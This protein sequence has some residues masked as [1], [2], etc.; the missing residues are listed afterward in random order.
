[1]IVNTIIAVILLTKVLADVEH[2]L[3]FLALLSVLI[4]FHEFGHF[5]FAKRAGV[6]VTDFALGF[7]PTLFAVRRGDTTYRVNALPLGGYCK[8]AGEDT[9]DDGS[10][11]PGNFQHKSIWARLVIIAAGPIFNIILAVLIF[12]Y[13][14]VVFGI[15][16][17]NTNVVETV[18]AG[19]PAQKAGLAPGDRIVALDGKK[20]NNGADMI[21]YIHQHAN[22]VVAVDVEHNGVVRHLRIQARSV[23]NGNK[24]EGQFG[25]APVR[26]VVHQP[27]VVALGYGFRAVGE[28]IVLQFT[29][30]TGAIRNHDASV[31]NGPV[32]IARAVISAEAYGPTVLLTLAATLSVVLGVINLLPFPALD[33][34]RI[35]F[36]LVELVRGRPIDPEKEGLVHLTGFALLMVLVLFATYHDILQWVSGR[37]GF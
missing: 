34:G 37:G 20:V 12:A 27:V 35:A 33:G 7:G 11:D 30:I 24:Q 23:A 31:I 21:D 32:G 19:S 6:R 18:L 5:V 1:M 17:G 25:F 3:I 13:I 36:L 9:A 29:G 16:T 15:P 4:I 22:K 26:T 14:G 28:T 2:V 8:M 10:M